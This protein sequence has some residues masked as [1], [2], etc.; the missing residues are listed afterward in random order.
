MTA[1]PLAHD[2]LRGL[3]DFEEPQE[4]QSQAPQLTVLDLPSRCANL[5]CS[6]ESHH[7][8]FTI[9]EAGGGQV[10]N[11]KPLRLWMCAVCASALRGLFAEAAVP[12]E[13]RSA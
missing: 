1:V 8:M 11:G 10:S 13:S 5:G 2:F 6:N 7:R 9:V 12:S 4:V 3:D